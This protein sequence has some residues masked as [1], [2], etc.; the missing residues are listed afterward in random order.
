MKA[1]VEK[2]HRLTISLPMLKQPRPSKS[3][4]S[5]IVVSSRG[6]RKT[7]I[8]IDGNELRLNVSGI[9]KKRGKRVA[10]NVFGG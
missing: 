8:M 3:G 1:R 2:R 5:M 6:F 4:K 9:T 10:R 7:G